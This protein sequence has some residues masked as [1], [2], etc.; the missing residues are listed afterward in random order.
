MAHLAASLSLGDFPVGQ[1][2]DL[3]YSLGF[4]LIGLRVL[5]HF[6]PAKCVRRYRCWAPFLSS[7]WAPGKYV[8]FD[9]Y[10]L[11]GLLSLAV[12]VQM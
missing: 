12:T 3:R 4:W 7:N 10:R 9:G 11:L 6:Y 2:L 5:T 8:L 1:P